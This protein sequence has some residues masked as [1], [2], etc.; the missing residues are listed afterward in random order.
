MFADSDIADLSI[1]GLGVSNIEPGKEGM[2]F[3]FDPI[4]VSAGEFVYLSY[5]STNFNNFFGFNPDITNNTLR[6]VRGVFGVE[7]YKNGSVID[8]FGDITIQA[9][10][11]D[12]WKFADSWAYRVDET[13]PDGT[14]FNVDNWI[15]PG[16]NTLDDET[17]NATA[18]DPVPLGTFSPGE[19]AR[20]QTGGVG[21]TPEPSTYGIIFSVFAVGLVVWRKRNR[22]KY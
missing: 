18:E 17:S 14:T 12:P 3:A 9:A 4:S 19:I 13:G 2:D 15:L 7:L 10:N 11:S 16:R 8:V 22:L 1:F 6:Q 21:V 20:D 5:E